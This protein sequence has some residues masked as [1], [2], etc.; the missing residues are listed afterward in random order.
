M[1]GIWMLI[2]GSVLSAV[3]G[4]A[5]LISGGMTD[6]RRG[7]GILACAAAL[8]IAALFLMY[9]AGAAQ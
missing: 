7:A 5:F 4:F 8:Q 6:P 1:A 2:G 9:L 3:A